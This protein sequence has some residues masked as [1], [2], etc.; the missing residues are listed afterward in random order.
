MRVA[1]CLSRLL[2]K[3]LVLRLGG[4]S[5]FI[6]DTISLLSRKRFESKVHDPKSKSKILLPAKHERLLF[7]F[8]ISFFFIFSVDHLCTHVHTTLYRA[9]YRTVYCVTYILPGGE[10]VA[11]RSPLLRSLPRTIWQMNDE[12]STSQS[13]T[14]SNLAFF[15]PL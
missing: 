15:I 3:S 4:T 6:G 10:V 9:P 5:E 12:S 14:S 1:F 7:F 2:T 8:I 13:S 11:F